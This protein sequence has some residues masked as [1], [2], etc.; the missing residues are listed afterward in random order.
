M[1][2]VIYTTFYNEGIRGFFKGYGPGISKIILGNA[3][4]FVLYEN[5]KLFFK[6]L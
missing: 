6:D 5:F 2:Q 3:L 4:G 1:I